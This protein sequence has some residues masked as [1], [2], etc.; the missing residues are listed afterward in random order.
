MSS[1]KVFI[2][3]LDGAGREIIDSLIGLGKLPAFRKLKEGGVMGRLRTTIPPIT[4]SAWSSFM[5]GKNPGKHGIFDFIHR[6]EGTYQ[7]SPIN[8]RLREGRPFWSWASDAGKK[9]CVFNVPVTY[10][11]EKLNG[12]MV[13]GMLTPSNKTDYTFPLSLAKELDRVTQG[14]RIHITESYSK[15]GEERFLKH[16]EEMTE[17]RKKAME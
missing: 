7:L 13:T 11:P 9:I 6:K 10:P 5:T 16:L 14:Y 17:K 1:E 8:A 4:G 12:M 15:G 3:G 2:L